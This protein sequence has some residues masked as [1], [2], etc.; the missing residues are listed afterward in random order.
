MEL[1]YVGTN[2]GGRDGKEVC[3]V[4]TSSNLIARCLPHALLCDYGLCETAK[5]RVAA[6]LLEQTFA[7][8]RIEIGY[9]AIRRL[10][11]FLH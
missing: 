3:R 1:A 2:N 7:R 10:Q 8:I 5:A 6:Q 9:P 4:C 11:I